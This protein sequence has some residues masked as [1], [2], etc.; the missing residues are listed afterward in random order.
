MLALPAAPL[1]IMPAP[2]A[3]VIS[4]PFAPEAAPGAPEE[5]PPAAIEVGIAPC[6][7]GLL[8]DGLVGMGPV[9]LDEGAGDEPAPGAGFEPAVAAPGPL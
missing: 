6:S 9:P 2:A 4:P 5:A 8:V 3:P 1:G 7:E